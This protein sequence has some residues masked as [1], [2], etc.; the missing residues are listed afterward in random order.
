M[1]PEIVLHGDEKKRFTGWGFPV[2]LGFVFAC[3]TNASTDAIVPFDR[4]YFYA[5]WLLFA[6]LFLAVFQIGFKIVQMGASDGLTKQA[7]KTNAFS[8]K[9]LLLRF[10]Y[11][12][13]KKSKF[14]DSLRILAAWLPYIV[15]LY[16]GVL[17]WDTG[18][19][20]AQFFG[21]S[22][23]GQKPGKIW[24]HHPF[25]DTYLYGGFIWLGHA[26]T[27]S[28][29]VGIFL[30]AI[31]QCVFVA[32]ALA[33]WL[34]YL[35][36]RGVGRVPL[37]IC[38][39]FFC[40]FPFFPIAFMSLSKD[41]THAAF[42]IAW[43]LMF[44][45]L[46]DTRLEKIKHPSFFL[47]FLIL[48]LCSSL[49]KKMGM[50]I[51]LFCLIILVFGKF[52]IRFKAAVA[53]IAA[54]LFAIVSIVLPNYYYPKA[55]IVPGGGQ[56]AFA[57]PI[58]LLGRSAHAYPQ[59]VTD[60]EKEVIESYLVYS[61]DQISTQYNPYIADPV[62]GYKLRKGASTPDFLKVWLKIGL[63]HPMTYLN[64]FV[65]LES[66]WISFS[67]NDKSSVSYKDVKKSVQYPVQLQMDASVYTVANEDTLGKLIPNK[68]KNWAQEIVD[69]ITSM[70][71][72][73][74][75]VNVLTY[76]AFWASVF[77]TFIAYLLWRKRKEYVTAK[78]MFQLLPYFVSAASLFV[79]PVS[80]VTG[81]GH[82]G[83]ATRYMFHTLLLAPI[84]IGLLLSLKKKPQKEK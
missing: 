45:R 23:F 72:S 44:M 35:K 40:F 17:Y 10:E 53:G 73:I 46:V 77:P 6:V 52:R 82:G 62:T 13:S 67:G 69:S 57:M 32:V 42:F 83:D 71:K 54:F 27:G 36:E 25:F 38:A 59:D 39:M 1:L 7:S 43:L 49:S 50:Y 12:Q 24:D 22:A 5:Q 47:G 61:W 55:N 11:G 14:K 18:D 2:V 84:V 8:N 48:G 9:F 79:Y 80:R 64:G 37:K 75:V 56:A 60:S 4:P 58:E 3:G 51:I 16:P 81:G 29:N 30:Y 19:Q 26:I 66:G 41:I 74:P 63:R 68:D 20:V 15:L 70:L 65:C 78:T 21:I 76:V 33:C 34:S 31:A 28:Y